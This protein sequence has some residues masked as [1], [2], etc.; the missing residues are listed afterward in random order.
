MFEHIRSRIGAIAV[1]QGL[2]TLLSRRF[3]PDMNRDTVANI[4][5]AGFE[6][7]ARA[8]CASTS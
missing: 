8:T 6:L 5:R 3:E 4:L 2:L 1:M 7:L